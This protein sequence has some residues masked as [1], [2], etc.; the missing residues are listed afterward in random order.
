MSKSN[1]N[2]SGCGGRGWF[3]FNAGTRESP[4]YEIQRCDQ[5]EQFGGDL[6]AMEAVE[7]VF[8][9]QPALLKFIE[10]I[11]GLKHEQEPDNNPFEHASEDYIATLNQLIL[12]ARELLGTADKCEKCG[13]TVPYVIGCPGGAVIART[14]STPARFEP[15]FTAR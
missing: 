9:N 1:R 15:A 6:A 12:E 2:C 3:F 5:C 11:A 4:R 13:V 7:E 8:R 14:A 10:K